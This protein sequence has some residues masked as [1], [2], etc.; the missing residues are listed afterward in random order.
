MN[1]INTAKS[2][3][4]FDTDIITRD[5]SAN[6]MADAHVFMTPSA[7]ANTA[8]RYLYN[9]LRYMIN[10]SPSHIGLHINADKFFECISYSS[11]SQRRSTDSWKYVFPSRHQ[12]EG[13]E[14]QSARAI[15]AEERWKDHSM[16]T[17]AI[18]PWCFTKY[19]EVRDHCQATRASNGSEDE[20]M[21]VDA[22]IG[23]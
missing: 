20:P 7:Y 10:Q 11:G 23:K 17:A 9:E 4:R 15:D 19:K 18:V 16:K 6:F 2:S 3:S 14:T 21:D 1:I 5:R 13:S 8:A 22:E 12:Q